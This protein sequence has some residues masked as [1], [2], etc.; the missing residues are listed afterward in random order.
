[1]NELWQ[2]ST[3]VAAISFVLARKL[4]GFNPDHA[5]L[6]GLL[7]DIGV[8]I[9]IGYAEKYQDLS[10]NEDELEKLIRHLRSQIGGMVLRQWG[11]SDDLVVCAEQAED[12][13]RNETDELDYCDLVLIAQLYS[14]V[15][16]P[17][18]NEVPGLHELPV[19]LKMMQA[20][21]TPESG[22]EILQE[23]NNEIEEMQTL[24]S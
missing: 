20:E 24:L 15:D 3:K 12:W 2:H 21:M 19:F 23:A 6:A 22:I 16:T 17:R 8:L 18:M 5:L 10:A 11:F 13:Y 4:G 14:F 1:M 7:H 9:I